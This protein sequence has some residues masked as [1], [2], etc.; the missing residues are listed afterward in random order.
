MRNALLPALAALFIAISQA[1]G[2]ELG[3]GETFIS[4][5]FVENSQY[6]VQF[7]Y[8]DGSL[9]K[10]APW[11]DRDAFL[12]DATFGAFFLSSKEAGFKGRYDFILD[13][14][15]KPWFLGLETAYYCDVKVLL[16]FVQ[17]D[18][19]RYGGMLDHWL[20]TFIFRADTFEFLADYDGTPYDITRFDSRYVPEVDSIMDERYLVSCFPEGRGRAFDFGLIDRKKL[21]GPDWCGPQGDRCRVRA[22]PTSGG[23]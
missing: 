15:F 5:D 10:V 20:T 14:A 6:S 11:L 8:S 22:T 2:H 17:R 18:M 13:G 16:V 9:I 23:G 7:D 4:L 21:Y 3:I 12:R 1:R 19:P